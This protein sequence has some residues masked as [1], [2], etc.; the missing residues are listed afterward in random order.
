MENEKWTLKTLPMVNQKNSNQAPMPHT[1]NTSKTQNME[2]Q[3]DVQ[4]S[5][6][7]NGPHDANEMDAE[8]LSMHLNDMQTFTYDAKIGDTNATT[9][10]DSGTTLSCISER[11]Y[12]KI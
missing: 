11:F 4:T 10:F 1:D 8:I 6:Q 7:V 3:L 9:L 2:H 12:T 5:N